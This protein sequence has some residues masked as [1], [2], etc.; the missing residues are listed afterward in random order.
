MKQ[1]LFVLLLL[2]SHSA[3]VAQK[4][5]EPPKPNL[6]KAIQAIKKGEFEEAL[7]AAEAMPTHSKTN[8]DAKSWFMRGVILISLDTS[9]AYTTKPNNLTSAGLAAIDSAKKWQEK[10]S[11]SKLSITEFDA[12]S[13][14]TYELDLAKCLQKYD[15]HY[16]IQA[17]K[18]YQRENF[19]GALD[20]VKKAMLFGS[21]TSL[22]LMAGSCAYNANKMG[23]AIK[24]FT[25]YFK[26]GGQNPTYTLAAVDLSLE[27]E[28]DYEKA[29]TLVNDILKV[30]PNN[31]EVRK[32]QFNI[33]YKLGRRDEAR[34]I[35][36]ANFKANPRD[37]D[38]AY[39]LA[40]LHSELMVE[41]LNNMKDTKM[42]EKSPFMV[43]FRANQK[44]TIKW[45][46]QTLAIDNKHL[47]AAILVATTTELDSKIIRRELDGL[48]YK[49]EK[50]KMDNLD[51]VLQQKL[52]EA[53][54]KWEACLKIDNKHRQT[55][56]QL[57]YIYNLI[58]DQPNADRIL[59][60]KK[61]FG[62]ND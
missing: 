17:D 23:D 8:T 15:M 7:S 51:K 39:I 18:D 24:G 9:S 32:R 2:I 43:S 49:K 5:K 45:A 56:D 58:P 41:D 48:D 38:A 10:G 22:F 11:K 55:L 30:Q 37:V 25:D 53:A 61:S 57:E 36:L 52:K 34:D 26:A 19:D 33:F 42:D 54:D 6:N 31:S 62:Y 59:K 20:L 13:N 50:A 14:S 3:L 44:E 27:F 35:Q 12:A 4:V 46:N 1:V 29:L 40:Q 21:D 60:I 28:K 47:D 16:R